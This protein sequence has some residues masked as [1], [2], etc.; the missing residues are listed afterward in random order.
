MDTDGGGWI[1]F[2]RRL[3]GSVDFNRNWTEYKS[4]FGDLSGEHWLGNEILVNLTSDDS[5][6]TWTIRIDLE[7]WNKET[8][9]AKYTDFK[10]VGDK[11]SLQL[12]GYDVS[13]TAGDSLD[14]HGGMA[15]STWDKDNANCAVDVGAWW[16][17]YDST[18]Y[19]LYRYPY[20][21]YRFSSLNSPYYPNGYYG[22]GAVGYIVWS[23]W[24]YG[25]SI[26]SSSMKIRET[27]M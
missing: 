9:F 10:I 17:Y 27:H 12:G 6:G 2:Q 25:K 5:Q 23:T 24:E 21:Y 8:A 16:Y 15:F 19:C 7:A 4:G 18:H 22:P 20:Y 26:K 1:V 14:Y 11:Y 3:D 13:S